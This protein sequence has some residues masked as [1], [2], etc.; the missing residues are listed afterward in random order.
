LTGNQF[1]TDVNKIRVF[2]MPVNTANPTLECG[3]C[4]VTDNEVKCKLNGGKPGVYNL[5]VSDDTG[6]DFDITNTTTT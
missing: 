2:F 3:V 5:R 4:T 1:G 6:N